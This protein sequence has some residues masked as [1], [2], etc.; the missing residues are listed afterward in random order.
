MTSKFDSLFEQLLTELTPVDITPGYSGSGE[1]IA[2]EFSEGAQGKYA[3]T[4]EQSKEAGKAYIAKL[5]DLGGRTDKNYKD[6]Q[7]DDIAPIVKQIGNLTGTNSVFAARVIH[8]ALRDAGIITDDRDGTT[9]LKIASPSKE[10]MEQVA[11]KAEEVASTLSTTSSDDEDLVYYKSGSFDL[12]D[13][14]LE[15]KWNA[16][17]DGNLE[18]SDIVKKIGTTAALDLLDKD[19]ILSTPRPEEEEGDKEYSENDTGEVATIEEPDEDEATGAVKR[20]EKFTQTWNRTMS[21]FAHSEE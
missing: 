12:D 4:P 7:K 9:T 13:A 18:W 5:R 1:E 14:A 11:D 2:P 16:L 10:Q 8:N 6:F 3:L 20:P 21:P 15:K 17:P 19:Q